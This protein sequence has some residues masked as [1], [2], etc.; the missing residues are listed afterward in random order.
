MIEMRRVIRL[1][2][3]AKLEK[4]LSRKQAEADGRRCANT[5]DVTAEWKRARQTKPLLAA[6]DT[7]KR[8]MGERERCMYCLDSH[9]TDVEHFW[10][11]AP[12]PDRMFHWPNLLLCCTE[13]GRLKGDRF[14]LAAGQPLLIDPT[15]DEPWEY[16]DFDP[17]TGNLVARFDQKADR[18]SFRGKGT[19]EVLQLDRRE[20]LA[21]GYRK[22]FRRL[23]RLVEQFI[24]RGE[25]SDDLYSTLRD[26]DDHGMVGWCFIGTG[27]KV[28]PFSKLRRRHPD[29]WGV[30]VASVE[31]LV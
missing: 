29:V 28:A 11:K 3:D 24:E 6:I 17:D 13:C 31:A 26:A 4:K 30:C 27:Q 21:A 14:P 15:V 25:K 8:M 2:L 16:L 1:P 19:V 5:L 7:L 9:G 20:A 10:P 22:T 18:Y 12:Y 23:S